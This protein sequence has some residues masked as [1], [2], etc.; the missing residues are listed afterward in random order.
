MVVKSNWGIWAIV[1]VILFGVSFVGCK[2]DDLFDLEKAKQI[3]KESFPVQNIDDNQ[4]WLTT[5]VVT[6]SITVIGEGSEVS[7]IRFYTDNPLNVENKARLLTQME[8]K[9]NVTQST[10]ID[11]PN[12]IPTLYIVKEDGK[13]NRMMKAVTVSDDVQKVTFGLNGAR[14]ARAVTVRS[15]VVK[16]DKPDLPDD[17]LFP[18]DISGIQNF[19]D[20]GE[21]KLISGEKYVVR[22]SHTNL[23]LGGKS[24]ITLYIAENLNISSLYLTPGSSMYILPGVSVTYKS[25][26]SFSQRDNIVSIG[27]GAIFDLGENNL[28]VNS[29]AA[30]YNKGTVVAKTFNMYGNTVY[31][32]GTIRIAGNGSVGTPCVFQNYG[33]YTS[34]DGKLEAN[35]GG[36]IYNEGEIVLNDGISVENSNA[37]IANLGTINAESLHTA[38]SGAFI[39][40]AGAT[41]II[42]DDTKVD[43]NANGWEN[44]G[45]YE[46][47]NF[48][49]LASGERV[50]NGCQLIIKDKFDMNG[51]NA[52]FMM[53]GGSYLQCKEA[54][55][56]NV[57]I[58]LG[59]GAFF[60][61]E[62]EARYGYD[63]QFTGVGD[64][65][66][67]L[68]LKKA[69]Q[70]SEQLSA[71]YTGNLL[72]A[73]DNHF[74][75]ELDQWN[76]RYKIEGAAMQV[77]TEN[78]TIDIAGT[79]C[80]PGIT[81]KPDEN[82]GNNPSPLQNY[83]YAFEDN[84]PQPGDYDFND[85]VLDI[86]APIKYGQQVEFDV[87]L[88][89]IGGTKHLGAGIRIVGDVQPVAA[90][91]MG[92]FS[93][94][95]NTIGG[96]NV[97]YMG[98]NN[99][100]GFEADCGSDIV[101]PL[102]GDAH[103]VLG[104]TGGRFMVNTAHDYTD[105]T[106]KTLKVVL[107]LGSE[108]E[109]AN[110]SYN[111]NFDVFITHNEVT[112]MAGQSYY[113]QP[114]VEVHLFEYRDHPTARGITFPQ[115]VDA[116]GKLTWGIMAPNFRYPTERTSITA[117]YNQFSAWAENMDS[118]IEWYES[119]ESGTTWR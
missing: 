103:V 97:L 29:N 96:S 70:E 63:N 14:S 32:G 17:I 16:Y 2:K 82:E 92:D 20:E 57:R 105:Y 4:T 72:V 75:K 76:P 18:D 62:E 51:S 61:V 80:N 113:Q 39:N 52:V 59:V 10:K 58:K 118:A 102:F 68:W 30:F 90:K 8:L 53:D 22:A 100:Y 119:P 64:G 45:Y 74:S 34:D 85:V 40:E 28:E 93:N 94:F 99:G 44:N 98:D 83:T 38:G 31:N 95:H 13:H 111:E 33:T 71:I 41:T 114:R 108:E 87:T 15:N 109:V 84:Y 115:M 46:T 24:Q 9:N 104:C 60:K 25:D 110:F 69:E 19:P 79:E 67:L 73:S 26:V 86:S 101:L 12:D 81:N 43:S 107:T 91:F 50:F 5:R 88:Q 78:T 54:Y 3:Y 35:G 11:V 42:H 1:A 66:A 89:A 48:E 77:G 37:L 7:T 106:P 116:A 65:W 56:N 36:Y 21:Y 47:D 117:A 6:V 112:N 23:D 27:S 55:F 49:I